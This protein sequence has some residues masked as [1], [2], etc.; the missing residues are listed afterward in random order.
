MAQDTGPCPRP[1]GLAASHPTTLTSASPPLGACCQCL[2]EQPWAQA[3]RAPVSQ[4]GLPAAEVNTGFRQPARAE[5]Q[6][7]HGGPWTQSFSLPDS[8]IFKVTRTALLPR[9][10]RVPTGL[11][12]PLRPWPPDPSLPVFPVTSHSAGQPSS[13]ETAVIGTTS[14]TGFLSVPPSHQPFQGPYFPWPP[15]SCLYFFVYLFFHLWEVL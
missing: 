4:G 5:A 9:G 6:L 3:S 11:G 15:L 10:G 2:Q 8:V 13:E 1:R 12:H 14:N 7:S